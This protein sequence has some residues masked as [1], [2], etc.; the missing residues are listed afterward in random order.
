MISEKF[1][2]FLVKQ[3]NAK[4][5]LAEPPEARWHDERD[6]SVF[7][8]VSSVT[9]YSGVHKQKECL[10]ADRLVS[11]VFVSTCEF[12]MRG[13][14]PEL[15]CENT[16][17]AVEI[18]GSMYWLFSKE[19]FV[20]MFDMPHKEFFEKYAGKKGSQA[21]DYYQRNETW[22]SDGYSAIDTKS[23]FAYSNNDDDASTE[24]F[25]VRLRKYITIAT[26]S[27]RDVQQEE[28]MMNQ[29]EDTAFRHKFLNEFYGK[30]WGVVN[31]ANYC[32]NKLMIGG[33]LVGV[34][35]PTHM[36]VGHTRFQFDYL[37]ECE[38]KFKVIGVFTFG[39]LQ[40]T[41]SEIWQP[42]GVE[43]VGG[44]IDEF[45]KGLLD[46][47]VEEHCASVVVGSMSDM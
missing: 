15:M 13:V 39:T 30:L 3:F 44:L 17:T 31:G 46:S 7:G 6:L 43:D 28:I 40:V 10:H 25:L 4:I 26:L 1:H 34:G 12:V 20:G 33:S 42:N 22:F 14:R 2:K 11:G 32:P 45:F 37:P 18:G 41:E 24:M 19:W 38:R 23:P 9:E 27:Y 16:P 8:Y 29:Q 47:L 5:I 36:L 35:S 21:R